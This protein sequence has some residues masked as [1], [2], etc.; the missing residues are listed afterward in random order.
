M[1]HQQHPMAPAL[2][3]DTRSRSEHQQRRSRDQPIRW[4]WSKH[5]VTDG[6]NE[7]HDLIAI[8]HNNWI[9]GTFDNSY[10]R[11][12]WFAARKWSW[13]HGDLEAGVYAGAMRGYSTCFGDDGS[14]SNV[15]P[16]VA[17]YITWHAGPVS[18]QVFLLGEAIALTVRVAL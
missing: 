14:G 15:C 5:L 3:R 7:R 16:M 17:P 9:A 18:P 4:A 2:I 12:T 13:K 6:L 1:D 11:E 10:D 8:E